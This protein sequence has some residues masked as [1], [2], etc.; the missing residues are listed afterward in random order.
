MSLNLAKAGCL[1]ASC[2]MEGV[3]LGGKLDQRT[4]GEGS[5]ILVHEAHEW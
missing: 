4:P 5:E 1:L 2:V 3:P